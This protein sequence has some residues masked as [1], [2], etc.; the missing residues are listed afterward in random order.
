MGTVY[1]RVRVAGEQYAIPVEQVV[2]VVPYA[3]VTPVPGAPIRRSA[4]TT[5]AGRS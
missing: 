2:E 4:C 1:V 5:C 3:D